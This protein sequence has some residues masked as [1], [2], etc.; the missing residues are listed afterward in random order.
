MRL[1]NRS[2][3]HQPLVR[4]RVRN[5][6]LHVFAARLVWI[7]FVIVLL[8][9]ACQTGIDPP[10]EALWY[11]KCEAGRWAADT[12]FLYA[13]RH[14]CDPY[15]GEH[16]TVY[17]DGSGTEAKKI[18]ADLA[19][20]II[21]ELIREFLVQ[22][23]EDE[24]Q[25]SP[26]YTYYIYAQKH[27]KNIKAMGYRNGF[28]IAAVD[29]IKDPGAYYDNPAGYRYVAKH[30]LTHVFQLTLT[31]WTRQHYIELDVWF[32]EGQANHIAGVREE[33]RVTT[34]AEYYEWI[35]DPSRVNPISIHNWSDFPD[36]NEYPIYFRIFPLPYAY[37]VDSEYGY[38]ITMNDIRELFRL[39]KEGDTFAEAFPKVIGVTLSYF[40]ENFYDLMEEYLTNLETVSR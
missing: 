32:R 35:S 20:E 33:H 1:S 6:V 21:S 12:Y 15:Y 29:C 16:F 22:S 4:L 13:Y 23:I 25:F 38:G 8:L 11:L 14:D 10:T 19:E 31:N 36:P 7:V 24:L 28:F 40:E 39:I 17:S 30:E 27:I 9:P 34:L 26:G 3:V 37:L 2:F 18:L 5:R